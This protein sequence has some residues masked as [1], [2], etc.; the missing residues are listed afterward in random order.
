MVAFTLYFMSH[1]FIL[2]HTIYC[3]NVVF[4][5]GIKCTGLLKFILNM[6]NCILSTIANKAV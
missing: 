1:F 5:D 6:L 4:K 3:I 2:H